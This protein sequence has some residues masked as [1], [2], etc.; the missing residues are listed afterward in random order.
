MSNQAP[1]KVIPRKRTSGKAPAKR[2]AKRTVRRQTKVDT[3]AAVRAWLLATD[4]VE[5]FTADASLHRKV[6][7]DELEVNGEPDSKGNQWMYFTD[8]PVEGRIKGIKREKRTQRRLDPEAAEK[9]LREKGLWDE[10]TE[11][12]V[13]L[14]EEK[15]LALNF[16]QE[17]KISD[18]DM[19]SLYAVTTTYA[20]CPQRV[21]L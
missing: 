6:I 1:E 5:R 19:E 12:I 7:L 2:T 15:L 17:A 20:F 10:C 11:T 3:R 13:V 4:A 18:E 9:Y 14:S 21:K 16:G 8:D